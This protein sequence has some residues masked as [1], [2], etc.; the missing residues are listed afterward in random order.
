MPELSVASVAKRARYAQRT[1]DVFRSVAFAHRDEHLHAQRRQV[2]RLV[3]DPATLAALVP[4]ALATVFPG[5]VL[6]MLRA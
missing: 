5:W 2:K 6:G 3:R 4:V 1:E